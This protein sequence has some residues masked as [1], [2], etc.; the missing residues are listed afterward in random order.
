MSFGDWNLSSWGCWNEQCLGIPGI[1]SWKITESYRFFGIS[2]VRR[3]HLAC[4]VKE[5][6][7]GFFGGSI[8]TSENSC[9][10]EQK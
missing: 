3:L 4:S 8:G 10:F 7:W 5:R 1:F 9:G 2:R 6:S